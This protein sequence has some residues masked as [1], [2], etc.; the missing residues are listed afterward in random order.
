KFGSKVA[1]A[2]VDVLQSGLRLTMTGELSQ[3]H[4]RPT[5]PRQIGEAQMTK[6]VARKRETPARR[7]ISSTALDQVESVI[8]CALFRRDS[9]RKSGRGLR[10]A[11]RRCPKYRRNRSLFVA[12]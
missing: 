1:A 10:L 3:L 7:A 9:E 5:G 2:Y 8:G 11:W 6:R 4:Q 12:E